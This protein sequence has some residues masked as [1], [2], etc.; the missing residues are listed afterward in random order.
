MSL[1]KTQ[2]IH[3][4]IMPIQSLNC[5]FLQRQLVERQYYVWT[6]AH[7]VMGNKLWLWLKPGKNIKRVEQNNF[8]C[9]TCKALKVKYWDYAVS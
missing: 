3:F 4:S 7:Y 6:N 8:F 1:S 5:R 2:L 9:E